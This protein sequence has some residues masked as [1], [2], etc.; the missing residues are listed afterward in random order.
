MEAS[1]S[2]EEGRKA[3]RLVQCAVCSF[4][5]QRRPGVDGCAEVCPLSAFLRPGR[6]LLVDPG[7]PRDPR[8][9]Q[10]LEVL[11]AEWHSATSATSLAE[12]LRISPS[13][14]RRLFKSDLGVPLGRYVRALR[15]H[16]AAR[17]LLTTDKRVSDICFGAG[18]EGVAI[19]DRAFRGAFGVTPSDY[20]QRAQ[21]KVQARTKGGDRGA[22]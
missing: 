15:L 1:K 6:A 7:K 14:F 3:R 16:H 19:F 12:R 20:R 10:A 21:A 8:V 9:R 11:Q 17:L 18:F 4:C 13:H 2:P 22:E 5:R